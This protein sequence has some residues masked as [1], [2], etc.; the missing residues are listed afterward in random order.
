MKTFFDEQRERQSKQKIFDSIERYRNEAVTI[1]NSID[2][3]IKQ[4]SNSKTQHNAKY[5]DL[6]KKIKLNTK[7]ELLEINQ[8][9]KQMEKKLA[10]N[11]ESLHCDIDAD[12]NL[13]K[14]LC[15]E[16]DYVD[17]IT[18][19]VIDYSAQI[20]QSVQTDLEKLDNTMYC[21]KYLAIYGLYRQKLST[22]LSRIQE[23]EKIMDTPIYY[24]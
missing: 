17:A 14:Y 9:F 7:I 18:T 1:I 2:N 23:Y 12:Q 8:K 3:V 24:A 22:S 21:D 19:D 10:L 11:Y 4:I 20:S 6:S 13:I 16:F 15:D 5:D